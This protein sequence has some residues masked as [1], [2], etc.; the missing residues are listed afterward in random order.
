M[1]MGN[2][3]LASIIRLKSFNHQHFRKKNLGV[4]RVKKEKLNNT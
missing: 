3:G 4:F 1:E 2:T